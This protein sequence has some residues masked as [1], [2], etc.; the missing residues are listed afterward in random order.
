MCGGYGT[1]FLTNELA[2][3]QI[4]LGS[5]KVANFF[6]ATDTAVVDQSSPINEPAPTLLSLRVW[7]VACAAL[8][9]DHSPMEGKS[10]R[11][12]H[13]PRAGSPLLGRQKAPCGGILAHMSVV[14]RQPHVKAT[15]RT[16]I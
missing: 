10:L 16:K 9:A 14:A 15:V 5:T 6:L 7:T 11:C 3:V 4:E 13:G 12:A 1:V 2:S 8:S